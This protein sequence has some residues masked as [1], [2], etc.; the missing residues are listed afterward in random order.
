[1]RSGAGRN[2]VV[3]AYLAEE[4]FHSGT[5]FAKLLVYAGIRCSQFHCYVVVKAGGLPFS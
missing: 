1:M 5:Y 3:V 2:H 4:Y